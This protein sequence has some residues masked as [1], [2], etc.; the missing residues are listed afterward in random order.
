MLS[1]SNSTISLIDKNQK[2]IRQGTRAKIKLNDIPIGH[3]RLKAIREGYLPF[4]ED[5]FIIENI[6]IVMIII[7]I[8]PIIL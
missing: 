3:Y 4:G 1:P 7:I 6:I 2:V 8:A 5:V